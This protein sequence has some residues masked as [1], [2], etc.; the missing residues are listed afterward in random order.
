MTGRIV[1]LLNVIEHICPGRIPCPI[2]FSVGGS[3]AIVGANGIGL[4]SA[5]F[6]SATATAYR[7]SSEIEGG[8]ID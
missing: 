5:P 2:C 8:P 3:E 6:P 7:R 4:R 1:E